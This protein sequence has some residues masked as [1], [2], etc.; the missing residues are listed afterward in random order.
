MKFIYYYIWVLLEK[1]FYFLNVVF[2]SMLAPIMKSTEA[3]RVKDLKASDQFNSAFV[4]FPGGFID[5]VAYGGVLVVEY[6]VIGLLVVAFDLSE[7]LFNP[8]W[9]FLFLLIIVAVFSYCWI[10]FRSIEWLKMK[11]LARG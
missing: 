1:A 10:Y 7:Y 2:S 11:I 4:K 9:R 3:S 8:N 5:W 6:F